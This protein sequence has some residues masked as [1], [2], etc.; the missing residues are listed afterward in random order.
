MSTKKHSIY[1][2]QEGPNGK[3]YWNRAGIAFQ[4]RDGSFTLKL[5]LFPETRLQLREDNF[6]E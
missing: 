1:V 3:S 6:A 4:N 5:D 2:V